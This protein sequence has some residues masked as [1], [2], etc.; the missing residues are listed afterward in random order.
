MM[1]EEENWY[2]GVPQPVDADG[3]VVPLTTRK[4]YDEKGSE[5]EVGGI[6][7]VDA[8][9]KAGYGS[10]W[11]VKEVGGPVLELAYLHIACP[12]SWERIEEDIESMS[13]TDCA[14]LYFGAG[15]DISC[16]ECPAESCAETCF[17]EAAR[18]VLRRCKAIARRDA[19]GAN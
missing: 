17:V 10:V 12:D 3:N 8:G 5:V 2:E 18:D 13:C 6:T 16:E 9:L 14:C 7:L 15:T 1:T 19:N 4:L 11:R